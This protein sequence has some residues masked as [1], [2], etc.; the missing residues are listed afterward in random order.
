MAASMVIMMDYQTTWRVDHLRKK[1][2][3]LSLNTLYFSGFQ[4]QSGFCLIHSLAEANV[5]YIPRDPSLVLHVPT[6]WWLAC[7]QSLPHMHVQKWDLA[8]IRMSNRPNRRRMRYH[9]ASDPLLALYTVVEIRQKLQ[10]G[11]G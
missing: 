10:V 9:C 2:A 11:H 3:Q 6:S 1:Q 5:M 4:S 8:R 7:S